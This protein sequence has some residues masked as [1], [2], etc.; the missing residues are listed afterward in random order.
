[1]PN[2]SSLPLTIRNLL[3]LAS[4]TCY[5]ACFAYVILLRAYSVTTAYQ[6]KLT[7]SCFVIE[8]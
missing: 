2:Y 4:V 1:M 8:A 5:L 6:G 7:G 3:Q